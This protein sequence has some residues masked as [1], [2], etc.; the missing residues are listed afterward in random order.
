MSKNFTQNLKQIN[1][2]NELTK[3]NEIY[4]KDENKYTTIIIN[5]Y[6]ENILFYNIINPVNDLI[7]QF[8]KLKI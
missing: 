8:N 3:C 1:I 5:N 4:N 7:R 6:G 2:N